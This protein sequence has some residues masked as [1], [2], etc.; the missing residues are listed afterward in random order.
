MT[1]AVVAAAAIAVPAL[2]WTL[3]PLLGRHTVRARWLAL[4]PDDRE[5]LLERKRA[6]LGALRELDFEHQSGH[7]SDADHADLRARYEAEAAAV[8]TALDRL[9]TAPPR[10]AAAVSA[11]ARG[12]RHPLAIG[13]GAAALVVF[14]IAIG[15]GI[16]RYTAPDS[17]AG[18][19][20]AGSR[21]LTDAPLIPPGTATSPA[22]ASPP[23]SRTAAG[24]ARPVPPEVLRGMLQAARAS[25]FEGRYGEA[26]AAY[27][28]VL[29]RDPKNVDA[30]TH[31]GLIV[32]M[33]G[34][35][36]AALETF[37]K[38]LAVDP[39]YGP[40]LLYRGQVLLEWKRDAAA[41]IASWE[42]FVA[43]TPPGEDRERVTKMIADAR[44]G[45]SARR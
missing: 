3:W 34:H 22:T 39:N 10:P 31:L 45:V 2:A 36:D 27:Q 12:W 33:G 8:L 24:A 16:T 40:A 37:D 4:P 5:A 44:A 19:P 32:A 42:K 21:P 20:P 17:T 7:V 9:G 15:A 28:A 13:A 29:K 23:D 1:G 11:A 26:I 30:M 18:M 25:L 43:I 14:G 6:A 38:A 35:A 41:A